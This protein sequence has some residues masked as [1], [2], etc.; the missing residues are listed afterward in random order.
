MR[1][2][3]GKVK[4][5]SISKTSVRRIYFKHERFLSSDSVYTAFKSEQ[6]IRNKIYKNLQ[7]GSADA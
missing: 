2:C 7:A 5:K 6:R 4:G 1:K 3:G